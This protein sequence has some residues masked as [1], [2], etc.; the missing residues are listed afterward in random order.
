M[1]A[2][3]ANTDCDRVRLQLMAARD[4]ETLPVSADSHPD[5]ARHLAS[6]SSCDRWLKD[7]ESMNSRF[8]GV[9]YP[10]SQAD[11][12][13]GIEGTLRQ[14]DSTSH[15]TRRLWILGASVLGWRALQLSIDLPFPMLHPLVPLAC[16]VAALW[17]IARD[18]LAI[19]TFAPELQKRGI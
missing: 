10:A 14:S 7:F 12:W 19:E 3:N 11:L 15:V 17:L 5:P 8:Q 2:V 16:A 9:S 1:S 13:A 18:P 6:C 4:G